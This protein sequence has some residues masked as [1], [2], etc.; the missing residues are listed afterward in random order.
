MQ[1]ASRTAEKN[2]D[3]MHLGEEHR[4]RPCNVR[5]R[6]RRWWTYREIDSSCLDKHLSASQKG[7]LAATVTTKATVNNFTGHTA[8]PASVDHAKIVPDF[9]GLRSVCG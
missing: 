7:V 3:D 5:A 9:V 4:I 6:S 8:Y 2:W 1:E